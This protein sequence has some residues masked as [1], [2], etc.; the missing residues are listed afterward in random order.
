[1]SQIEKIPCWKNA[2]SKK[3]ITHWERVRKSES[4]KINNS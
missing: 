3:V 2:V 1:M 4:G